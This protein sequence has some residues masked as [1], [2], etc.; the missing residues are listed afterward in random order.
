MP[1]HMGHVYLI[2]SALQLAEEL[3]VLVCTLEKEPISGSLRYEWVK[4]TFPKL[5]IVHVQEEV[6]SYPHEDPNFWVYW[7]KIF[8]QYLPENIEVFICGEE[9]GYEVGQRMGIA[10]KI[11][12]RDGLISA[13]KFRKN[14]LSNWSFI[15]NI[16]RPHYVKRIILTGPE[17]TGKTTLAKQLAEHFQTN[18]VP[19][20]G[21]EHFVAHNGKLSIDDISIIASTQLEREELAA[22]ESNRFLFCDT[23]LIVTQV[24][25]EIYFQKS[26]EWIVSHNHLKKYD[27]YLLMDIDIPWEDDG[28]REFPNLR[29][30][31]FKRLKEE[32]DSHQ[33]N[34]CVISGTGEERLKSAVNE[35]ETRFISNP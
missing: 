31:H 27:L 28:T 11:I 10:S 18:W 2:E 14:P 26:P 29:E 24:W 23:D 7:M 17:S 15:P 16:V 1:L 30:F 20:Y 25:S 4:K 34:Y 8:H 32:L 21:R 6:P 35:I 22:I 13:T 9:Y 19:E 3:T 5:N 33:L 12:Q